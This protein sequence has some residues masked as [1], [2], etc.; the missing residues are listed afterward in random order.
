MRKYLSMASFSFSYLVLLFYLSVSSAARRLDYS[1][2]SCSLATSS[3]IA[4]SQ[5][6]AHQHWVSVTSSGCFKKIIFL[7]W[8]FLCIK[9][10]LILCELLFH[11]ITIFTITRK[12]FMCN[13]K[14]LSGLKKTFL[15]AKVFHGFSFEFHFFSFLCAPKVQLLSQY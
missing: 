7:Y 12:I 9:D 6:I 3:V 4:L 2:P 13:G 8:N 1:I 5:L 15:L 14:V 10:V 11:L